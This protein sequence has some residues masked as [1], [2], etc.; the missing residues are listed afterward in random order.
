ML[1]KL[2]HVFQQRLQHSRKHANNDIQLC[3]E[4][5][6]QKAYFHYL[7]AQVIIE[8]DV[9]IGID[10]S[11][12]KFTQAEFLSLLIHGYAGTRDEA[13]NNDLLEVLFPRQN[14]TFYNMDKF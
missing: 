11:Y 10:Y 9:R 8:Y 7:S 2:S 12:F 14:S 13:F 1:T 6:G 4:C 5:V 3:L